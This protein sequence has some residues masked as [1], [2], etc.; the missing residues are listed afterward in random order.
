MSELLKVEQRGHTAILTM[1]NPPA[2]T[3]TPES[4]RRLREVIAELEADPDN[5][6]LILASE[7]EKFFSAGADLKRFHHEDTG[8]AYEFIKAF[9]VAFGALADYRGVA[10]AAITGF[11]MGGGLECA[12]ACDIRVAEA[13]A[14]LA[15]PECSVGLLPGGLGTQHLPW[16]VGEGWAKRMILLGERVGAQQALEIGLVQEVVP[17]GK[18]LEK[19]LELAARVE[20]QSP[21]SVRVCKQLIMSARHRP[22]ESGFQFE[23]DGFMNLWGMA[24]QKEGV[25]AF[26]EKRKPVWK[27][28]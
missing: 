25:A 2:N 3:W 27:N 23:R 11:A 10:I 17:T 15:L 21:P 19:A 26:V 12:L 1:N 22:L 8:A 6:A 20:G 16:L 18:A 7:S 28:A 13:Q 24:D 9:G 5:Y 4:L 14:Q